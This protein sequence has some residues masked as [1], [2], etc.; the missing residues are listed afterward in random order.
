VRFARHLVSIALIAFSA[1][2]A[3]AGEQLRTAQQ[4]AWQK[5]FAEAERI[6]RDVLA[7]TPT[8]RAAAMGLGQVLLWEQRY[9]EAADV[10]R[11]LLPEAEARKGLATA[12]YWAGDFRSALRDFSLVHDADARKAIAEIK[13]ASAPLGAAGMSFSSDDQPLRRAAVSAEYTFFTDPLTKWTASAGTYAF[14]PSATAPFASIAGSTVFPWQRLRA[15]G[16]L[17]AIRFPDGRNAVLGGLSLTRGSLGLE[18]DRHEI[19]YTLGSLHNHPS[20]TTATLAWKHGPSNIAVHAI[21]YFDHN[22]GRAADAYHLV[23]VAGPL[24]LGAAASWRDTDESRFHGTAY[25]PYWTPQRL[26]EGRLVAA[27]AFR[28]VRL[29]LDGGW[30]RDRINGA[31]HPWRASAD[32]ALPFGATLTIERQSTI[33]YRVTSFHL[34]IVRRADPL[35]RER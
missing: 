13:S 11:R 28:N 18:I 9:A 24:S 17:R 5:R 35:H 16:S 3:T 8:S 2:A 26:I 12:E 15:G 34:T 30:A 14:D 1:H 29:H 7:H 23:H 10:Y 25:D 32:V 21:R 4:L 20:E 19:L 33:F 31:F 22:S 27:A 6:Y